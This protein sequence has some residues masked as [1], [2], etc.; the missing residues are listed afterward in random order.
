MKWATVY[1]FLLNLL[2]LSTCAP[3]DSLIGTTVNGQI[4]FDGNPIN[5]RPFRCPLRLCP[6]HGPSSWL[7][8]WFR[9]QHVCWCPW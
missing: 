3:A 9:E 1:L 4:Y 2:L 6:R 8:S 7:P 5:Y